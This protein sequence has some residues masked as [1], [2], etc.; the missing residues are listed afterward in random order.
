M[1]ISPEA[2]VASFAL[3]VSLLAYG[4]TKIQADAAEVEAKA[5]LAQAAT[6]A[7]DARLRAIVD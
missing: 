7:K 6:A 1:N 2:I 5:A 4:K 3:L